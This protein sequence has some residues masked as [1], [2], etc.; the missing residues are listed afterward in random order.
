[1]I[2]FFHKLLAF[3]DARSRLHIALLFVP[4]S[5]VAVMEMA[6]IAMIIPVFSALFDNGEKQGI[7][8]YIHDIMPADMADDQFLLW[9]AGIF[10]GCVFRSHRHFQ[11]SVEFQP[12]NSEL[13]PFLVPGGQEGAPRKTG[14]ALGR[15]LILAPPKDVHPPRRSGRDLSQL[16]ATR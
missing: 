2:T 5:V 11:A 16:L 4:M 14:G 6:S 10:G 9:T 13:G 1:M 12:R 15:S 8:R 3:L 7:G